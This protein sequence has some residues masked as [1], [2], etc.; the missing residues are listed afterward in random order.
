MSK[1]L[2]G[3]FFIF[4]LVV[5]LL[6]AVAPTGQALAA[7]GV[8]TWVSQTPVAPS[9]TDTVLV[10]INQPTIEGENVGLEYY[11][12]T[13]Y[14][15]V[16]ASYDVADTY[17]DANWYATIPA[18]PVGTTVSYQLYMY[19]TDVNTGIKDTWSG[20]NWT[21]K[22]V[23]TSWYTGDGP[24]TIS[25]A[26]QLAG[27][28]TLVN[29]GN[30][31][32]GKTILLGADIDLSA[33]TNWEPIGTGFGG[34]GSKTFEGTF[35]GQNRT[36]SNLTSDRPTQDYVGLFGNIWGLGSVSNLKLS[37]VTV[38]GHEYV[39]GLTS[40]VYSS[41]NV[42]NVDVQTATIT[43]NHFAGSIAGYVDSGL[44]TDLHAVDV[45]VSVT[46]AD[47]DGD[48]DKAGGLIGYMYSGQL[49]DC[50]ATDVSVTA[51]RNAGGLI[52][53]AGASTI[54][55]CSV[56]GATV[57]VSNTTG[58]H[59]S[60]YAGG[61]LGQASGAV[62]LI[63][64]SVTDP[65]VSSY[66][67]AFA[68]A[69]VGGPLSNVTSSGV[70]LTLNVGFGQAYA[71]L[72]DA[73]AV[74]PSGLAEVT[75]AVH[76]DQTFTTTGHGTP[77]LAKGAAVVNLI[78]APAVTGEVKLTLAG[79]Y[80]G[81]LNAIGA[82]LN[83]EGLTLINGRDK[84]GEG[85]DPWEFAY[86]EPDSASVT[87]TECK[88]NHG[89]MVS[90]D[91]IFDNCLFS[92]QPLTF[93]PDTT[94]Y[95]LN[96]YA[97]WIH[98]FGDVLVKNSTFE[99]FEYGGVK[100]SW[101]MYATGA[102]LSLTLQENT[103]VNIGN[104]GDH[105]IAN[106]DGAVSVTITGN[107]VVD[108]YLG[109]A[110]DE[111]AA[112]LEIDPIT[113]EP[114]IVV[115]NNIWAAPSVVY[116]DDDWATMV[117]GA[118]PDGTGAATI[119][120]YDAFA[121]IQEG[122]DAV[123]EGGIVNV[124][125]GLYEGF[126]YIYKDISLIGPNAGISAGVI[127]G[128]RGDEAVIKGPSDDWLALYAD[129][130]GVTI[131]GFTIDGSLLDPGTDY[132]AGIY[133]AANDFLVQNNVFTNFE[134]GMAILTSG[135]YSG[136]LTG[137][138]IKDNSMVN[139]TVG[140]NDYN[141]GMYLQS[142]L[143]TVSGNVVG[144]Y[145]AGI[146]IQPYNAPGSGEVI[147]NSFSTYSTGMYFNYTEN[148]TADWSFEG[149][150]VVGIPYPSGMTIGD[151]KGIKVETFYEG[152]VDF[153]GNSVLVGTSDA[154]NKYLYQEVGVTNGTR[155]ASHNWWG[156]ALGPQFP[157]EGD[158]QTAKWCAD[159]G[160]TTF[161]PDDYGKVTISG[162]PFTQ[163]GAIKL[164]VDGVNYYLPA[165]TTIQNSSPCFEV[166]ADD[167]HIYT[168]YPAA[169]KCVPTEGS[170]GIWVAD[171]VENLRVVN[172]EFDGTGQT[173][174]DGIHFEGA[175]TNFQII[176]NYFHDLSGSAIEFVGAPAGTIQDVYG[177]Y[178]VGTNSITL[179]AGTLNAAYNSWGT[180][181]VPTAPTD[182]TV[183]PHTHAEI[184]VTPAVGGEVLKDTEVVFTVNGK[185]QSLTGAQ[186][187]LSYPTTQ[188]ELLSAVANDTTWDQYALVDTSVTGKI[189][190]ALS[191]NAAVSGDP[192][193]ML[194][195]TFKALAYADDLTLTFSET[196]DVFAMYPLPEPNYSN[197]VYTFAQTGVTD[198]DIIGLPVVTITM[199]PE[200]YYAGIPIPFEVE[201][202]N[203]NGGTY[204][205][206]TFDID[207]P[208]GSVLEYFNGTEWVIATLPF[209]VGD[210]TPDQILTLQF[211]VTL[212]QPGDNT[213]AIDL[214]DGTDL[215]GSDSVTITIA[216]NF[217]VLGTFAMQ[218]RTIRSGIPVI[219]TIGDYAPEFATVDLLL[220][221]LSA[222][223][224]YGGTYLITTNQPRYLNVTA[225][226]LKN[227]D[228]YGDVTLE[229]LTLRAGN[230]IWINASDGTPNTVIDVS[231]ASMV[232]DNW[233]S[234]S[235]IDADVNFDLK[236]NIQDLAL[237]GGNMDLTSEDAYGSWDPVLP[238]PAP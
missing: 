216:G 197:H 125:A 215:I 75:Y 134:N 169:A 212:D 49:S 129:V 217:N 180:Y 2:F 138:D 74:V 17:A 35:D 104:G 167:V 33:Y 182:V 110:T 89:V 228:V 210:L 142:S 121:T 72:A 227:I 143:G 157:I 218:G 63:T 162:T 159:E 123:A 208:V 116:V 94:D 43:G 21:Y 193:E 51:V 150:E 206:L 86:F 236:V 106:L 18:H 78:K 80:Y 48:G 200:P 192:V 1:K 156:S 202:D 119:F 99:N 47:S 98:N 107:L 101:N 203:T 64:I 214:M 88:F 131:D 198:L 172:L 204:T 189:T 60:P 31:F 149:N 155:D 132:V 199:G 70:E 7:I 23:D 196:A 84:S 151:F 207:L 42:T 93:P 195:L 10:L 96:D 34:A 179:G 76:D 26:D 103:F 105:T 126:L 9:S 58:S 91:A 24:Y 67:S 136:Y 16:A 83:V 32:S 30:N 87:F 15:K 71:T 25:T 62:T 111:Q 140:T 115:Q 194:T 229:P 90:I 130:D 165:G 233:G 188:L 158:V 173:T 65:I 133:G 81:T 114:T 108:S 128:T 36:I 5:G 139:A 154:I 147:N 46:Y 234:T 6:F 124:A 223:L 14:T 221:N 175:I 161:L 77:D 186:F 238:V 92:R 8:P 4:L 231:D 164:Y 174:G 82:Q 163:D 57:T 40:L 61:V 184:Y 53:A 168:D 171:G 113:P 117:P 11:D 37:N 187:E 183:A 55:N 222:T 235:D 27:L 137:V 230:A 13:T 100:S 3:K 232:T 118:D 160:C 44:H 205:G 181:E 141:F 191:A 120:G 185:I 122:I 112:L 145:R 29:A 97:L 220:D 127:P 28:A 144:N 38:T 66:D 209:D 166:Y 226:L 22:V 56:D 109:H 178:F 50:S 201:V 19:Y 146:Q 12:G 79:V 85:T 190:V 225:D 153:E 41:A 152:N 68:G 148:A 211:R 170:D 20:F 52:G 59:A 176:N 237:V 102:D 45:T 135:G 224:Q 219:F 54:T 213:I 69:V 73:M 177:N 95:S 39:G